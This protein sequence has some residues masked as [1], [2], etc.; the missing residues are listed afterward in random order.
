MGPN[1]YNSYHSCPF[2]SPFF[3]AFLRSNLSERLKLSFFR[4]DVLVY[5][6]KVKKVNAKCDFPRYTYTIFIFEW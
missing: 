4:F 5:Y 2:R 3:W 1:A 6:P